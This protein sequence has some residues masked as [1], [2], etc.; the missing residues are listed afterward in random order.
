MNERRKDPIGFIGHELRIQLCL[1][2]RFARA[3]CAAAS[4]SLVKNSTFGFFS[5]EIRSFRRRTS[6]KALL[7]TMP[8][9]EC[10]S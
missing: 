5:R 7:V 3:E 4:I 8:S 6:S 10:K 1:S 9:L 2:L